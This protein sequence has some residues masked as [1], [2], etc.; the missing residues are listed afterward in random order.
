MLI[1]GHIINYNLR[2][3]HWNQWQCHLSSAVLDAGINCFFPSSCFRAPPPVICLHTCLH[4]PLCRHVLL[5]L[6]LLSAI[7]CDITSMPGYVAARECIQARTTRSLLQLADYAM[8]KSVPI[9]AYGLSRIPLQPPGGL[10]ARELALVAD[11]GSVYIEGCCLHSSM[12][13]DINVERGGCKLLFMHM[14]KWT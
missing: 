6:V 9:R 1:R 2:Y 11:T 5:L 3:A 13:N 4:S 12:W 7:C 14:E 8:A 10:R